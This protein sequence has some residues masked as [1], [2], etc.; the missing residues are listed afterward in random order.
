MPSGLG[1]RT[2]LLRAGLDAAVHSSRRGPAANPEARVL[3]DRAALRD[4]QL[5]H[6][7]GREKALETTEANL[8]APAGRAAPLGTTSPMTGSKTRAPF[9][10]TTNKDTSAPDPGQPPRKPDHRE[11]AWQG[12]RLVVNRDPASAVATAPSRLPTLRLTG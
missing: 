8:G 11:W 2:R 7:A 6:G 4:R 1:Q 3:A 12:Q 10:S 9:G 5:E